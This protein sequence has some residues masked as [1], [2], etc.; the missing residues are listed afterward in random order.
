MAGMYES[1]Q[2]PWENHLRAAITRVTPHVDTYANYRPV[3]TYTSL[4][5]I[6]LSTYYI[7][8]MS[9]QGEVELAEDLVEAHRLL[10]LV[11]DE[12]GLARV[13]YVD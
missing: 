11:A 10:E 2:S 4:P 3:Y 12:P 5:T 6:E 13:A 1:F 7:Y 8:A 9:H